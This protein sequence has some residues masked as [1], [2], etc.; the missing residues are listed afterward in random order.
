MIYWKNSFSAGWLQTFPERIDLEDCFY[1]FDSN[2]SYSVDIE[3]DIPY[4]FPLSVLSRVIIQNSDSVEHIPP[5]I[6]FWIGSTLY[7][8]YGCSITMYYEGD[9][10]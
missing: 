2:A 6:Y 4:A 1:H 9:I 7:E 8:S 5:V 10:R 3:G